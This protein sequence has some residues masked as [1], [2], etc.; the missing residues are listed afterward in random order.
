MLTRCLFCV[1]ITFVV[2]CA[3]ME[4][5]YSQ[6]YPDFKTVDELLDWY[7]IAMDHAETN[8]ASMG[9]A[10]I[11][12]S[13]SPGFVVYDW[14]DV[15]LSQ[16][17]EPRNLYYSEVRRTFAGGE[18]ADIW[19]KYLV[20][21]DKKYYSI[22][23]FSN[24][25]GLIPKPKED[26]SGQP[27]EEISRHM[28]VPNMFML[29][30]LSNGAYI[31]FHAEK[32]H[33]LSQLAALRL[34]EGKIEG[35]SAKGFFVNKDFGLELEFHK[36]FGWMPT[37]AKGYYRDM[38]KKGVV[39]RSHFTIVHHEVE[40]EWIQCNVGEFV[41]LPKKVV[42]FVAKISPKS[43]NNQT[44]QVSA[45]WIR[46][47]CNAEMFNDDAVNSERGSK[48]PLHDVKQ[49]LFQLEKQKPNAQRK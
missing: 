1:S 44:M 4:K 41:F 3:M 42:N 13:S 30:V 9:H 23:P 36:E 34:L 6:K 15:R 7:K 40:T 8:Y 14:F 11:S 48:G 2:H 26:P 33:L 25:L 32:P 17:T 49:E 24:E 5:T 43:K 38:E 47:K 28:V 18:A 21:A 31:A 12:G 20:R 39:D 27:K 29:A 10:D 19:E 35:D 45:V 22:G 46:G 16:R 37:K